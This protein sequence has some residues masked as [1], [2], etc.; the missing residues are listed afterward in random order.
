MAA[1]YRVTMSC[2]FLLIQDQA[3]IN[4]KVDV[5]RLLKLETYNR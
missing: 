2:M 3:S 4:Q 5:C 1:A